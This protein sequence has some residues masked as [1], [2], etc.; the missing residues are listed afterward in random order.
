MFG[1]QKKREDEPSAIPP[2]VKAKA[3]L[4]KTLV[5]TSIHDR[6]DYAETRKQRKEEF[7][8]K[9]ETLFISEE[10][11]EAYRREFQRYENAY[12]R[13]LRQKISLSDFEMLSLLG[14]GAFGKV[15]LTRKKDTGEVLALKQLSKK[16]VNTTK[17]LT[18]LMVERDVLMNKKD[19]PWLVRLYYS[20]QDE[21]NLYLAMEYVPGGDMWALLSKVGSLKEEYARFY[22]AEMINAVA[23]LHK[24]GYIHRDLKPDN[25]LIDRTGHLKLTD[26]GL[27]KAGLKAN[28]RS[29][30][31]IINSEAAVSNS[32][33][34]FAERKKSYRAR[35]KMAFSFVGTLSYMAI[36]I[37]AQEGYSNTVDW[38]SI[39]CMLFEML[40]GMP[41]FYAETD[42]QI[43]MNVW[44]F[45]KT[46]VRPLSEDGE[47]VIGDAAWDLICGL[48]KTPNKRLGKNGVDEIQ[49]HRFFQTIDWNN[50]RDS[51]K[52]PPPFVPNLANDA[53]T[54]Y[55]SGDASAMTPSIEAFLNNIYEI[56][57]IG[58]QKFC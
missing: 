47:F 16:T 34:T 12:L 19:S 35:E 29:S 40:A 44:Q 20:F 32:S 36:E 15:F 17:K 4:A 31:R 58:R 57:A 41:P 28:F 39:G 52:N 1:G 21:K 24:L 45:K 54:A 42:E 14:R 23:S 49:N 13:L 43:V 7:D 30:L 3:E 26:F 51:E 50:L 10:E 5:G 9:I 2:S 33:A 55:F 25:F 6:I 53:D 8:R 48:I 18:R 56:T 38:W 46:L 37:L 22:A 27:S 11:K